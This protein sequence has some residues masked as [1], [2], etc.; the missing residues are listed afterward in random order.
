MKKLIEVWK[1]D[2][3]IAFKVSVFAICQAVIGAIFVTI[4][5]LPTVLITVLLVIAQ[6]EAFNLD[7]AVIG[8]IL[9]WVLWNYFG[10]VYRRVTDAEHGPIFAL[11]HWVDK[12]ERKV[13]KWLKRM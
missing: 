7:H 2:A 3:T 10:S 13:E 6:G 9:F 1:N 5:L 12:K 8:T 11:Y 4:F